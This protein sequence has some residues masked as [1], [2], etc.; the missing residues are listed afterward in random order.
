MDQK[1][2]EELVADTRLE[3][4]S[5]KY[6]G[7]V[8]LIGVGNFVRLGTYAQGSEIYFPKPES[9]VSEAR[10][11]RI[12]KEYTGGNDTELAKRYGLTI[13]QIWNILR[14]VPI[15]GQITMDDYLARMEDSGK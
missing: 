10:N 7:I 5:E 12:K 8:E 13:K 6:R 14:D 4:V 1:L 9:I 11:R 2:L 3:D 15:P